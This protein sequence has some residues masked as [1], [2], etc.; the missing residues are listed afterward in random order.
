MSEEIALDLCLVLQPIILQPQIMENTFY[1]VCSSSLSIVNN[2]SKCLA[3]F[4]VSLPSPCKNIYCNFTNFLP[5]ALIV[6]SLHRIEICCHI[7]E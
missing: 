5:F 3:Y 2:N 1:V 6:R 4:P 7:N